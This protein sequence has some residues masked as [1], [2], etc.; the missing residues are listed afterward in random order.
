MV[1][2]V[3]LVSGTCAGWVKPLARY[4]KRKYHNGMVEVALGATAGPTP[5]VSFTT[6]RISMDTDFE[7][8]FTQQ[9]MLLALPD[10]DIKSYLAR[11]AN[12]NKEM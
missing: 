6:L 10:E 12:P 9:D 7:E 5:N 1:M 3:S 2:G 11:R 8:F 4:W